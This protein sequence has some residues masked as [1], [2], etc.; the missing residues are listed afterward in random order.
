MAQSLE[1]WSTKSKEA[2]SLYEVRLTLLDTK[3]VFLSVRLN[4]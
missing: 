3:P 4:C 1:G 2:P